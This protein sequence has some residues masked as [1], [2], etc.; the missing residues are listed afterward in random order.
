MLST[1]FEGLSPETA[2][3]LIDRLT[4]EAA[5][6]RATNRLA[7]YRPYPK[8]AEFHANGATFRERLLMASNQ[9]GKT[10]CGASEA[11]FHLTGRYPDWWEGRRFSRPIEMWAGSDTSESTRDTV[12]TNLI[13]PPADESR[14]GT[15][16]L[17]RECIVDTA[18]RQ[19]VA[20]ALDTVIVRHVS[21][22]NSYLGFKS[23]DQKRQKWQGT[24]KD[25]IWLDEEPPMDI[26]TEALTRTNAV[27]DG[28]IY[29]TFTPLLGMSD[30]VMMFLKSEE[31]NAMVRG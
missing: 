18:R 11:A 10:F 19:G 21:G 6:R 22:G 15:A 27:D 7:D 12:Q 16:A 31:V 8:Q 1:S 9:T 25:V 30:V 2:L 29:V 5:R 28:I 23:Y 17:P 26:Y 3:V 4:T 14:W 13:G 20:D 24:K